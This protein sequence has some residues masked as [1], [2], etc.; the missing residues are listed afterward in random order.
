MKQKRLTVLFGVLS[1]LMIAFIWGNSIQTRAQSSGQ[2]LSLLGWLKP[3]LD[4]MGR[5]DEELFHVLIRKVAHL[6]EFAA[7][8]LC[9]GGFTY[10][11]GWLRQRTYVALP[12]LITLGVAVIDEF[13]QLFSARGSLVGDIV[14]DYCGALVGLALVATMSRLVKRKRKGA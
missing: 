2:S 14:L 6:A 3:L 5:I 4:P 9:V 10:H 13:I 8:G 1:I 7:L 12:M 11:L